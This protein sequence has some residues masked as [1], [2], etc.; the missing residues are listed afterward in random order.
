[1]RKNHKISTFHENWFHWYIII[2]F[3]RMHETNNDIIKLTKLP[4]NISYTQI[5]EL[6]TKLH[7]SPLYINCNCE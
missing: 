3:D 6:F 2:T 4:L 5:N 1:M 7:K